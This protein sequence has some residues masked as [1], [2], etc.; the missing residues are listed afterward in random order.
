M[1]TFKTAFEQHWINKAA[2][3]AEAGHEVTGASYA[4]ISIAIS[5]Q[6]IAEALEA[7]VQMAQETHTDVRETSAVFRASLEMGAKDR[8]SVLEGP[9]AEQLKEAFPGKEPP[10]PASPVGDAPEPIYDSSLFDLDDS[11]TVT[12][13]A[14]YGV[15]HRMMQK[16]ANLC[17]RHKREK[18]PTPTSSTCERCAEELKAT[19]FKVRDAK[20]TMDW[21]QVA[22]NGGPPCFHVEVNTPDG[23]PIYCGRAMRWQGHE[24]CII[25]RF[26]SLNDLLY[27]HSTVEPEMNRGDGK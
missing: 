27:G 7:T 20:P 18:L 15:A 1:T 26:V 17:N 14:R 11:K 2:E 4:Q 6:R 22:L 5:L 9:I 24:D 12:L 13:G 3:S 10:W 25:H 8:S 21:Q 19:K 16:L 23:Q